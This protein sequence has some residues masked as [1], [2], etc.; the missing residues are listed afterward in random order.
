MISIIIPVYN[1]EEYLRNTIDSILSQDCCDVELLLIDDG[2]SDGSG[3]I[4]DNYAEDNAC[5]RAFHKQN[6]GVSSARNLGIENAHGEWVM[7]VDSDDELLP[8]AMATINGCLSGDGKDQDLIL[9][10]YVCN[11]ISVEEPF[12]QSVSMSDYFSNILS[13]KVVST[14]WAKVYRT[15]RIKA[16]RFN[17]G[18]K[19]GEDLLFNFEYVA[20]IGADCKIMSCDKAIYAYNVRQDSA[21]HMRSISVEYKTLNKIAV[22]IMKS[23]VGNR[24]DSEIALFE[25]I[26]LFHSFWRAQKYPASDEVRRMKHLSKQIMGLHPVDVITRYLYIISF[27]QSLAKLYLGYRF[28]RARLKQG[29]DRAIGT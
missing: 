11:G 4:C 6:G 8:S 25:A 12:E 29:L 22:P 20:A 16:L 13:Y 10:R 21:M 18:L 19:I 15:S 1:T 9:F 5:V 26:N 23:Y 24:F 27:S 7:F 17:K 3:K 14:P 2:S 28:W